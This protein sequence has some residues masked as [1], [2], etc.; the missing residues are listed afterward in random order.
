MSKRT[1]CIQRCSSLLML[2]NALLRSI[3]LQVNSLARERLA[4]IVA[5]SSTFL[6][7]PALIV[8]H[9]CNSLFT[10]RF[11]LDTHLRVCKKFS[12]FS[13]DE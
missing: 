8:A 7:Q 10:H 9:A 1:P 12:S 4:F 6:Q 13:V 2:E 11:V 5:Y 3:T